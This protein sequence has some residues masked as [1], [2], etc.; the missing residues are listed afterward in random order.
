RAELVEHQE[1]IEAR[2]AL[3]GEDAGQVDAG[4]VGRGLA[5]ALFENLAVAHL[6]LLKVGMSGM[7]RLL[8]EY[9][10]RVFS[11]FLS[12]LSIYWLL[13]RGERIRPYKCRG[14]W[15]YSAIC[16]LRDWV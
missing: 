3:L 5:G 6:N 8:I 1:G 10:V 16:S 9:M 14:C 12:H 13:C 4:T 15:L 2:H 11:L 7:L